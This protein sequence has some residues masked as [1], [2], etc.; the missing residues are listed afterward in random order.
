MGGA[1]GALSI[2]IAKKHQDIKL[3]NCDLEPVKILAEEYLE[4][5][6]MSE[7]VEV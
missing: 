7:R 3:Y 2:E 4:E 5:K 1:L 6:G